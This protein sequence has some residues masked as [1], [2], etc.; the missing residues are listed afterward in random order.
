MPTHYASVASRS[1][2]GRILARRQRRTDCPSIF[3]YDSKTTAMSANFG[4]PSLLFT[5]VCCHWRDVAHSTP[6]I[7]SRIKVMLPGRLIEPL[8]PFS[9]PGLA[10]SVWQSTSHHLYILH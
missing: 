2:T 1:S 7:W 5:R 9:T 8:T 6:E 4:S 3:S 10:R